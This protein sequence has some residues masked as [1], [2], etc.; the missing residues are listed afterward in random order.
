[1]IRFQKLLKRFR[2]FIARAITQWII[3]FFVAVQNASRCICIHTTNQIPSERGVSYQIQMHPHLYKEMSKSCRL[4]G[5]DG[6]KQ[7]LSAL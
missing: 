7:S 2:D 1:M 4:H 6:C 3:D 5:N